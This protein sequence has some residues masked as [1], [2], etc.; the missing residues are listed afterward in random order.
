[1]IER[2]SPV[3]YLVMLE[4]GD[5]HHVV[6]GQERW[7][8]VGWCDC[9]GFAHTSNE[10]PCAHLCAVYLA[11]ESNESDVRGQA[12]ERGPTSALIDRESRE[13]LPITIGDET[14]SRPYREF[15]ADGTAT[16]S[17][18][19]QCKRCGIEVMT[20]D[21]HTATHHVGCQS[22]AVFGRPEA[23]Q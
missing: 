18:I 8:T 2:S 12:I 22:D 15:G 14:W 9:K 10:T 20:G 4:G 3:D 16:G 7:A 1:M 23:R 11:N 21:R 5:A 19:V 17:W 6:F 13:L